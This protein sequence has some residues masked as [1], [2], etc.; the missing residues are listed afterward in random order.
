MAQKL[1]DVIFKVLCPECKAKKERGELGLNCKMC[2]FIKYHNTVANKRL[3][4]H[5][6]QKYPDWVWLKVYDKETKALSATYKN[7]YRNSAG[8]L[9][10][11]LPS[12]N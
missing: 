11:D 4:D 8:V 3:I 10:R 6:D 7:W 1:Y 9:T 12:G 5:I 2:Q